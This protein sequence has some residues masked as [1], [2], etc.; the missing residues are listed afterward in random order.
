MQIL[1]SLEQTVLFLSVSIV[2][3]MTVL[4]GATGRINSTEQGASWKI[5]LELTPA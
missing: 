1:S 3:E 4:I 2:S 5:S